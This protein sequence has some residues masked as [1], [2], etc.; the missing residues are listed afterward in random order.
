M[1]IQNRIKMMTFIVVSFLRI[2]RNIIYTSLLSSSSSLGNHEYSPCLHEFFTVSTEISFFTYNP[3][4]ATSFL[5]GGLVVPFI[6]PSA[7]IQHSHLI[8]KCFLYGLLMPI[9]TGWHKY[10]HPLRIWSTSTPRACI[11]FTTDAIMASVGI[12]EQDWYHIFRSS[13]N[14]RL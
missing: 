10:V 5:I 7:I 3:H 12:Q 6:R 11:S 1:A 14:I 2:S 4:C 9:S 13:V 8:H